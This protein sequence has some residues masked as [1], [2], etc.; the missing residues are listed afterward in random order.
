MKRRKN[1]EKNEKRAKKQD[2]NPKLVAQASILA[3][4]TSIMGYLTADRAI[5]EPETA[6][7]VNKWIILSKNVLILLFCSYFS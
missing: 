3:Q 6:A 4:V 7:E 2:T 5:L 1:V